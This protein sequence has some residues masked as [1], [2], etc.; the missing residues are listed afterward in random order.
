MRSFYF[1]II[2]YEVFQMDEF[3]SKNNAL[4]S[5]FFGKN[6]CCFCYF[7]GGEVAGLNI[8]FGSILVF[9]NYVIGDDSVG[10]EDVLWKIV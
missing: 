4:V 8:D 5:Y 10:N 3:G 6:C 9:D 7:D 2:C 1:L